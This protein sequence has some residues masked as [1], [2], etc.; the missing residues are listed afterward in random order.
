MY[1][2]LQSPLSINVG[3]Y[4]GLSR[5]SSSVGGKGG[6]ID[7]EANVVIAGAV[8]SNDSREGRGSEVGRSVIQKNYLATIYQVNQGVKSR[9]ISVISMKLKS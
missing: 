2:T 7:Q 9:L 1:D 4:L 6:V 5:S 8:P 3:R